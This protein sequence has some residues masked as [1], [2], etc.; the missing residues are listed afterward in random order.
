MKI[1]LKKEVCGSHEQCTGLTNRRILL[2][3]ANVDTKRYIQMYPKCFWVL[4]LSFYY[5]KLGKLI[6]T[7]STFKSFYFWTKLM[8]ST[9][10][11]VH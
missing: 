5:T 3:Y 8:H 1:L 11:A 4:L 10:G 7:Q 9:L 2:L 6:Q